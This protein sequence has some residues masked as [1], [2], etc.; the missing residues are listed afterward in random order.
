MVSII[1]HSLG[2]FTIGCMN[3]RML[4]ISVKR[5]YLGSEWK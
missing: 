5:P 4:H 2:V 1:S 3:Q